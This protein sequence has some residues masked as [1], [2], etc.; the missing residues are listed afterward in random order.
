MYV[1]QTIILEICRLATAHKKQCAK[2]LRMQVFPG[3]SSILIYVH[4]MVH[5]HIH[6]YAIHHCSQKDTKNPPAIVVNDFSLSL[7]LYLS[8]PLC[9]DII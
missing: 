3:T 1:S 7:S 5:V 8:L 2:E 9:I 6:A 4:M